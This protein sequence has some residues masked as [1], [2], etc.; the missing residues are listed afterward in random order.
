M[1]DEVVSS[2]LK[3]DH[4]LVAGELNTYNGKRYAHVRILVPSAVEDDWIHT[5]KGVAIL[6]DRVGELKAAVDRLAD[7]ASR[8]VV[9]GRIAVGKEEIRIGVNTLNGNVY[10]YVRRFY[11]KGDDWL[12]TRKG[13]SIRVEQVPE[14]VDLVQALASEA[15]V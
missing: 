12:P 11:Q 13:V 5:D 1:E 6:V 15:G 2:F 4:E 14:L 10:A 7:V 3:N 8:D 9:V